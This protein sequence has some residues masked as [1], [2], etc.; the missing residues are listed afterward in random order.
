MK[1]IDYFNQ[2]IKENKENNET[3][4]YQYCADDLQDDKFSINSLNLLNYS[5]E[6]INLSKKNLFLAEEK[7]IQH[8]SSAKN[9]NLNIIFNE[10]EHEN[11]LTKALLILYNKNFFNIL[12]FSLLNNKHISKDFA[13]K[14]KE[15]EDQKYS[16]FFSIRG[17]TEY[18]YYFFKK[19]SKSMLLLDCKTYLKVLTLKVL[20]YAD[21]FENN[22]LEELFFFKL[23]QLNNNDCID[24]FDFLQSLIAES[25]VDSINIR[26]NELLNLTYLSC[27]FPHQ[28]VNSRNDSSRVTGIILE[29]IKGDIVLVEKSGE[30]KSLVILINLKFYCLERLISLLNSY[31]DLSLSNYISCLEKINSKK[32]FIYKKINE[33]KQKITGKSSKNEETVSLVYKVLNEL[34]GKSLSVEEVCVEYSESASINHYKFKEILTSL[35][36]NTIINNTYK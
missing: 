9:V 25:S 12:I 32:S 10:K 6:E 13:K 18:T 28:T 24:I 3:L 14:I 4:E 8:D 33:F 16:N 5:S 2:F 31:E 30:N 22:F 26:G 20:F 17:I 35:K 11:L 7:L 36:K 23:R 27:N 34:K 1:F 19:V 29:S 21:K 15:S